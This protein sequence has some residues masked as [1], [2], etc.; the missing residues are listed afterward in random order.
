M[1]N[2][3]KNIRIGFEDYKIEFD[4]LQIKYEKLGR[5]IYEPPTIIIDSRLDE[6]ATANVLMHEILHGVSARYLETELTERQVEILA[7][8]L[9]TMFR[10]NVLLFTNVINDSKKGGGI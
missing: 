8:L 9:S 7:N 4:E 3:Y 10:D 5:I 2:K 6:R 1:I